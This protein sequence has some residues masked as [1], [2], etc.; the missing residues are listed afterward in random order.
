MS[1]WPGLQDAERV[2]GVYL[3]APPSAFEAHYGAVRA[4]EGRILTDAQVRALPEA[5][6]LWNAEEWRMRARSAARLCAHLAV[7]GPGRRVLEVGCGNGWLS[8]LLQR[9]GHTVIGIDPFT[10]ELEQA[11]R[12]FPGGPAFARADL[13]ASPLPMGGFDAVVFAASIQ[14]FPD[15]TA[16][17]RRAL[18]LLAPGGEV[19]V[20][21]TVLYTGPREAAAAKARSRAYYTALGFPEMA[22]HYHAHG[23]NEMSVVGTRRVLSAPSLWKRLRG[24]ASPFTHA[25]IVP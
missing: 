19:H 23:L 5:P 15:I 11:A 22:A 20:L 2:N 14:Y 17:L 10:E 18:T 9:A 4:R 6:G 1:A 3:F 21:D 12:C 7:R 8:G 16:T 25:V 24:D 13:F